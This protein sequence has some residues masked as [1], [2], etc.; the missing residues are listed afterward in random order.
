MLYFIICSSGAQGTGIYLIN[1][2][3]QLTNT[4]DKQLIQEYIDEPFLM[5]DKLKF[6][7][8]VYAVIKSINPLSIYIA[9]EGKSLSVMN[10][11][12]VYLISRKYLMFF[13]L[14]IWC[15]GRENAVISKA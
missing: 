13:E 15:V 8:R 10:E 9:R 1:S 14:V 2:D 4:A 5:K 6:D 7:F 3:E 11:K 12:S